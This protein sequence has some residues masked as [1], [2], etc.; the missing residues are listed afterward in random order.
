MLG[1]IKII[2]YTHYASGFLNT[3]KKILL[4]TRQLCENFNTYLI[5]LNQFY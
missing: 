3:E 1:L 5:K 4:K 2:L